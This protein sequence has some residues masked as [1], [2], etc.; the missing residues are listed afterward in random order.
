M[1]R[2]AL[3]IVALLVSSLLVT[4]SAQQTQAATLDDFVITNYVA[5]MKLSRGESKR[6]ELQVTETITANFNHS[7]TNH[8]LERAFVKQYDSHSTNF[9]LISVTDENGVPQPHHWSNDTLRIGDKDT[10]VKGIKTYKIRYSQQDVTK[11]YQD[12]NKNEFYW[13]VVG[14][15]WRVPIQSAS[16]NLT[17]SDDLIN[18]VNTSMPFCYYGKSGATTRC[19]VNETG[20]G[21]SINQ[22]NLL[23]QN[24][25]SVAVGFNPNT[26]MPYEMSLMDKVKTWVLISSIIGF[27]SALI[28]S[29]RVSVM[30]WHWSGRRRELG[31]IVPEYLPPKEASVTSSAS[32]LSTAGLLKTVGTTM[33]A[34]LIDLAVRHYVKLYEVKEKKFFQS[35]EFEV[36][37]VKDLSDLRWE[38]RELISDM[39]DS[40]L[41]GKRINLKDLNGNSGYYKR[42]LNNDKELEK[43]L[44]T[45]YGFKEE[46][47][48]PKKLLKK[49]GLIA[50]IVGGFTLA[51]P[52]FIVGIIL[53][54]ASLFTFHRLTDKGVALNRYLE[55][56]KMYIGVAEK[57][58]LKLLQSPE[59]AEKVGDSSTDAK[60]IVLYEKVLPY[61]IVFGQEKEWAKQLSELYSQTQSQ[62]DWYN[63]HSGIFTAA[64]FSSG[65][66]NLSGAASSVSS[67][68]SSTG[69]SSGGGSSGGGGGGGGGG[70]W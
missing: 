16:I 14:V 49:T 53:F 30:I 36:E 51:I 27:V 65:L 20:R 21:Y 23:P 67:A 60:R 40:T 1:I 58:R 61:A 45:E 4:L 57:E 35:A 42:T 48:E 59:G 29:I 64:A 38:E 43:R 17:L 56:L 26:F 68:S 5:D 31:T 33:S 25:I 37:I 10:Y 6:S 47:K 22:S 50:T 13:D 46:Y 69:G 24:G 9:Q 12:T 8:G 55:G 15:E 39:F 3:V 19:V 32:L 41:V 18:E 28:L 54:I 7:N 52:L 66:S 11:F 62:P 63:G 44:R 2:R 34:Q 70:G